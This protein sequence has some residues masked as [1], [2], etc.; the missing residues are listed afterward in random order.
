M[1]TSMRMNEWLY[2]ILLVATLTDWLT[3]WCAQV[4]T[5]GVLRDWRRYAAEDFIQGGR[6]VGRR[7]LLSDALRK[8]T[9]R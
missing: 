2:E 8:E 7:D 9:F 4:P 5:S 3:D 6:V 1:L